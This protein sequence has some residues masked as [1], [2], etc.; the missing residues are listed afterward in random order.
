MTYIIEV[1]IERGSCIVQDYEINGIIY[2]TEIF[3]G[4]TNEGTGV[5][6]CR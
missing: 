2:H 6:R 3:Y 4:T 1:P 5:I